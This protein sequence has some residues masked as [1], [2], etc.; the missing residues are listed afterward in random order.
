M[1]VL[2]AIEHR[3]AEIEELKLRHVRAHMLTIVGR[4]HTP[5]EILLLK[6]AISAV[7]YLAESVEIPLGSVAKFLRLYTSGA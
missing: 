1:A 5:V 4:N 3:S 7:D 2:Q 6:E